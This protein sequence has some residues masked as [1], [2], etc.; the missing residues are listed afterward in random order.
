MENKFKPIPDS[1]CC[2]W[3]PDP[4]C[5]CCRRRSRCSVWWWPDRTAWT[6]C[7][8]PVGLADQTSRPWLYRSHQ[9]L[10]LEE[11]TNTQS[12][13][14]SRAWAAPSLNMMRRLHCLP[15][16]P[17]VLLFCPKEKLVLE[18]E[19]PNRPVVALDVAVAGPN[20]PPAPAAM[21]LVGPFLPAW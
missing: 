10:L 7:C 16:A 3:W 15:G 12:V 8:L 1:P 6:G 13:N 4:W 19:E 17:K 21:G 5:W 11:H 18:A 20:K 14:T 9:Q 2:W